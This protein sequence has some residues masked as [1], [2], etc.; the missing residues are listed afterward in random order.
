MRDRRRHYSNACVWRKYFLDCR[1][2]VVFSPVV[3]NDD[4]YWD[5]ITNLLST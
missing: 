5:I 1:N 3:K 2:D 4:Q